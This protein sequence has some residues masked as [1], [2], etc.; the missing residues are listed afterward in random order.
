MAKKNNTTDR[1]AEMM[2]K[3]FKST[4]S[5]A[6]INVLENRLTTRLDRIEHLLLAEQ[7]ARLRTWRSG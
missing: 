7:S 1:L 5:K 6:D 4:A 2:N 3:G